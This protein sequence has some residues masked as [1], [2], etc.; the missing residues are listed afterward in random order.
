[1]RRYI[2]Y[3]LTAVLLMGILVGCGQQGNQPSTPV[4][5][6]V[7]TK[8]TESNTATEGNHATEG[9][10]PTQDIQATEATGIGDATDPTAT[11]SNCAHLL[12]AQWTVTERATCTNEGNRYKTCSL[13]NEKVSEII[14]RLDHEPGTWKQVPGKVSTCSQEGQ[15]YQTCRQCD[16]ILLYVNMEKK[17]HTLNAAGDKCTVCGEVLAK[18]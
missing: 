14:P 13:C 2:A 11:E 16:E 12:S 1:M 9:N 4:N 15:Q 7:P 18:G 5:N 10:Q 6:N 3:I 17:A 8:T